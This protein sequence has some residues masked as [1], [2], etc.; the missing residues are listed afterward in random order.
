MGREKRVGSWKS[1]NKVKVINTFTCDTTET[2][3]FWLLLP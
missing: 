3:L 2:G 1:E